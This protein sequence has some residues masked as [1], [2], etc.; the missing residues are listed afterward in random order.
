MVSIALWRPLIGA[1]Y[2]GLAME[3]F[4]DYERGVRID[5]KAVSGASSCEVATWS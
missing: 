3:C 4:N 5:C 1:P 2:K